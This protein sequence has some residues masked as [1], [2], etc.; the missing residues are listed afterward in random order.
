MYIGAEFPTADETREMSK[1]KYIN[2]PFLRKIYLAIM[3]TINLCGNLHEVSVSDEFIGIYADA[4]K[5]Y[6]EIVN[7]L[8]DKK[9]YAVRW[10][11]IED[12]QYTNSNNNSKYTINFKISWR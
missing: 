2:D 4:R 11:M 10:E 1:D 9:S 12:E 6:E 8:C 7:Y 3:N 5:Y